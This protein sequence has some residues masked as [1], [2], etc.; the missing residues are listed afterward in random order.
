MARLGFL[1]PGDTAEV[2]VTVRHRCPAFVFGSAL[3]PRN[4][5]TYWWDTPSA[6]LACAGDAQLDRDLAVISAAIAERLDGLTDYRRHLDEL[7][8]RPE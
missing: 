3:G 4:L 5:V 8:E 1:E 6:G 2:T 7:Q